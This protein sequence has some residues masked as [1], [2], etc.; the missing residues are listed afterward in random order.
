MHRRPGNDEEAAQRL[1]DAT[2]YI[3]LPKTIK[4]YKNHLTTII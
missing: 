3:H 1:L 4:T 2:I